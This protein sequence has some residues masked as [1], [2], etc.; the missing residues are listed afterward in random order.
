[1]LNFIF[2]LWPVDAALSA[3]SLFTTQRESSHGIDF[4]FSF[5]VPG[6][7]E[8]SQVGVGE[9][10]ETQRDNCLLWIFQIMYSKQM[11]LNKTPRVD[12]S[13]SRVQMNK[14]TIYQKP[15]SNEIA[16]SS[17]NLNNG[18]SCSPFWFK[19]FLPRMTRPSHLDYP[20]AES[21]WC[22]LLWLGALGYSGQGYSALWCLER[23]QL[24][25]KQMMMVILL[26]LLR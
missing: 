10:V 1:M 2:R 15:S 4:M 9:G 12:D 18:Q 14:S 6:T 11:N 20:R 26:C 21:C 13:S 22:W 16:V 23:H 19:I 8:T 17:H 25:S 7:R 24:L 3:F 5:V